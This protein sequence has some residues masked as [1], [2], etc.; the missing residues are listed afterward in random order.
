MSFTGVTDQVSNPSHLGAGRR[1]RPCPR[2]RD[3]RAVG[4]RYATSPLPA[5]RPFGHRPKRLRGLLIRDTREREKARRG[6]RGLLDRRVRILLEEAQQPAG[7]D[8]RVT[9]A[10]LRVG[11]ADLREVFRC[12][13]GH[14]QVAALQRP[15]ECRIGVTG[16]ARRSSFPGAGVA[17][18]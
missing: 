3:A 7:R 17:S 8:P 14:E 13:H 4:S 10:I 9:T 12:G 18:L 5:S 15:L 2:L 11:E 16:R 1:P 6:E